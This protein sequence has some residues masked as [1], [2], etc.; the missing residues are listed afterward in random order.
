MEVWIWL[1]IVIILSVIESLTAS[2]V[3]IWFIISSI[4]SL[5]LSIFDVSFY[6]C[7]IVFVVLGLILMLTTRKSMNKF[8]K[9]KGEKT[10]L[11]RII[12]KKG[13]VTEKIDKNHIG[14][15]KVDGKNWSAYSSETLLEGDFV[16]ILKIDSVKLE[17][18]KWEE[19]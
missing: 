17:V 4:F 12:G 7:F 13:I 6:V 9:I 11:D 5:I 14:E 1:A 18:M 16:K 10:N 2:I 8:L 15:V 19:K 3:S